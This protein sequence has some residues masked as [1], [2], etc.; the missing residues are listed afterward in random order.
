MG[1]SALILCR[2]SVAAVRS[3]L[4]RTTDDRRLTTPFP[5]P[6][7]LTN[8]RIPGKNQIASTHG[9]LLEIRCVHRKHLPARYLLPEHLNRPHMRE[10]VPEAVVVFDGRCQPH[11]VVPR[12]DALLAQNQDNFLPHVHRETAEHRPCPRR[13]RVKR[14]QHELKGDNSA[15]LASKEDLIGQGRGFATGRHRIQILSLMAASR[16]WPRDLLACLTEEGF[17]QH[18]REEG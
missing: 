8:S 5:S 1:R 9:R 6:R 12:C 10:F 17:R 18:R 13:Q 16:L 3:G 7:H 2:L 15:P 14:I 4:L 11:S